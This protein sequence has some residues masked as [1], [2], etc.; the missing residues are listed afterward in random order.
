MI[1]YTLE[2]KTFSLSY[3]ELKEQYTRICEMGN[4]E[5]IGNLLTVLHTACMICFLKELPTYNILSDVGIIHQ[6]VHLMED[7]NDIEFLEDTRAKFKQQLE[8]V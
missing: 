6:I 2:D 3:S 5:F 1:H 8:L 7:K 4:K